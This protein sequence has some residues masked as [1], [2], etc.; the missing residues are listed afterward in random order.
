[1]SSSIDHHN[2]TQLGNAS[3]SDDAASMAVSVSGKS[4]SNDN[5]IKC[6]TTESDSGI[7]QQTAPVAYRQG[8]IPGIYY[9]YQINAIPV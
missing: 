8:N 9:P 6:T 1:M 4:N 5:L 2:V 7:Q 3:S